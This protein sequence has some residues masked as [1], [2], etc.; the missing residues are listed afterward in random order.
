MVSA[1]GA[2]VDPA[3][4]ESQLPPFAVLMNTWKGTA[5]VLERVTEARTICPPLE[6]RETEAGLAVIRLP[7]GFV[8]LTVRATPAELTPK[9]STWASAGRE[10]GLPRKVKVDA[11]V[12]MSASCYDCSGSSHVSP[13][14]NS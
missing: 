7:D 1:V 12:K 8:L 5:P 3:I 4:K 10:R 9:I 2:V 14:S 11:Y 13:V 6:A